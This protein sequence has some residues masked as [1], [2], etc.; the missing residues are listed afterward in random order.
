MINNKK[1]CVFYNVKE[2]NQNMCV[3]F[4]NSLMQCKNKYFRVYWSIKHIL[5]VLLNR[6]MYIVIDAIN[7][8]RSHEFMKSL[9]DFINKI[10]VYKRQSSEYGTVPI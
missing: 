7:E 9:S 6:S 4:E 8:S 1:I 3:Y 5:C 10:D 2:I